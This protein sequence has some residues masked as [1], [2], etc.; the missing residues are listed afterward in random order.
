LVRTSAAGWPNGKALLSGG[1]DC[2]FESRSRRLSFEFLSRIVCTHTLISMKLYSWFLFV[3]F[4]PPLVG[5][6][7]RYLVP[8]FEAGTCP[9]TGDKE[10]PIKKHNF[11]FF[12]FNLA[13]YCRYILYIII[14]SYS[15]A[16]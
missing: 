6:G 11:F 1:K 12:S 8:R 13:V 16:I 5:V 9:S 10:T 7:S 15:C 14:L 2:G 4:Q 3:D